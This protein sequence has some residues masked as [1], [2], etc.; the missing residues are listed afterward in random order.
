LA[1]CPNNWDKVAP[2]ISAREARE[3]QL[4]FVTALA[5]GLASLLGKL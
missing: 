3:Q 1:W 4:L 5:A 2:A